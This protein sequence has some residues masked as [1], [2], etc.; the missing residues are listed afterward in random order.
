MVNFELVHF[1]GKNEGG[2]IH[3]KKRGGIDVV[4]QRVLAPQHISH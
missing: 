1:G 4:G 3:W 2:Y